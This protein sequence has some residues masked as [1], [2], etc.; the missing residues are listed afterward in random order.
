MGKVFLEIFNEGITPHEMNA[1]RGGSSAQSCTCASGAI[2]DCGCYDKC[3][4]HGEGSKLV[5]SCNGLV[6][7]RLS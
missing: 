6:V 3:T 5:C 1:V 7:Y 2:Y 4:C